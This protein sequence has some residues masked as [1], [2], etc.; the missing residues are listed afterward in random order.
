MYYTIYKTT[1]L[2]NGKFYIG[3]HKTKILEDNYLGSGKLLKR[4]IKKY[5]IENF[6]KEI[7]LICSSEEEMN[8]KEKE[9]VVLSEDS[10]N[11]CSGGKGGFG[12]IN[13]NNLK[14][15]VVISEKRKLEISKFFKGKPR[16]EKDKKK[17][18]ESIKKLNRTGIR[19]P[20]FGKKHS[21]K[22]KKIIKEKVSI[23]M[24]GEK[25]PNFGKRWITNGHKNI[26]LRLEKL[27]DGFKF[28][29]T[30]L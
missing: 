1:N 20:F 16:S 6:K 18:S 13:K 4:A 24:S 27:P 29:I 26:Y 15:K 17:I 12:Y 30:K 21:D 2:I 14:A 25:N 11:L 22:T 10:Y 7:I 5:G 3:K 9:L 28:G 8:V 19:N 23:N